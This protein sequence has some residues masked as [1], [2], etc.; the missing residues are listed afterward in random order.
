MTKDN[1]RRV[2]FSE[3]I[4]AIRNKYSENERPTPE[5]FTHLARLWGFQ[6]FSQFGVL[7]SQTESIPLREPLSAS[8]YFASS[9]S[10]HWLYGISAQTSISGISYAP[11]LFNS[12]GFTSQND[13]REAAVD[14]I[15][16]FFS[17]ESQSSSSTMLLLRV[18]IKTLEDFAHPTLDLFLGETGGSR[19]R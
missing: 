9:T 17:R 4:N 6:T 5:C 3:E 7:E 15:T 2:D 12:I 14:E 11:N 1:I 8:I 18:A 13:A 19:G 16:R 10:G